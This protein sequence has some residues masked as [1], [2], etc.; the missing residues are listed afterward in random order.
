MYLFIFI[1]AVFRILQ[2]NQ[3]AFSHNTINYF[4]ITKI[5]RFPFFVGSHNR[6]KPISHY[7]KKLI[8]YA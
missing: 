6:E 4:I 3:V 8:W 1:Y 2:T 7:I 5:R